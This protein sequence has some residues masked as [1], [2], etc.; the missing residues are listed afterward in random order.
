[1][2]ITSLLFFIYYA[3]LDSV[4]RR[5]DM[6]RITQLKSALELEDLDFINMV[7]DLNIDYDE[8]DLR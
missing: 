4:Q 2:I 3:K 6:N 7:N 1:M 5:N 8:Q